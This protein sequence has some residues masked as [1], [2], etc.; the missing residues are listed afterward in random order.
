[1]KSFPLSVINSIL[2]SPV[3]TNQVGELVY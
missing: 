1:V 2:T 3:L